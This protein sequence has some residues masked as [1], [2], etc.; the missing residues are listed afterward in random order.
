MMSKIVKGYVSTGKVG[1]KIEFEFKLD[2]DYSEE[3]V[4]QLAWEI[5]MDY[6]DFD[7]E[8]VEDV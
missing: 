5:A 6:V 4:R 7:Y 1:S 2:S 3:V 8:V